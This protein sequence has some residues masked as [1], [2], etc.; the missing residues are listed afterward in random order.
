MNARCPECGW[1]TPTGACGRCN[2]E[3]AN[4]CDG[5]SFLLVVPCG[6]VAGHD[7]AHVG[8]V[9]DSR[10]RRRVAW[11]DDYSARVIPMGRTTRRLPKSQK[12]R[13]SAFGV[14]AEGVNSVPEPVRNC[15]C[16]CR[17]TWSVEPQCI[18][19][20]L[21]PGWRWMRA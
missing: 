18:C 5:M 11:W 10:S 13:F 6:L 14:T 4:R 19:C 7:G 1:P 16:R 20:V 9:S 21:P 8:V 2:N 3:A 17:S 15:T 12:H